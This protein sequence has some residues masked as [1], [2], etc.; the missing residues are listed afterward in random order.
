MSMLHVHF[1]RFSRW[2]SLTFV[3]RH[4]MH[5]YF[6]SKCISLQI[7]QMRFLFF[8]VL[9]QSINTKTLRIYKKYAL[10]SPHEYMNFSTFNL[11]GWR[12][13]LYVLLDIFFM[14]VEIIHVPLHLAF[15]AYVDVCCFHQCLMWRGESWWWFRLQ[16]F[17]NILKHFTTPSILKKMYIFQKRIHSN[18]LFINKPF[19]NQPSAHFYTPVAIKIEESH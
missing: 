9:M 6:K 13:F 17:S 4:L 18:A 1:H 19:F 16:N 5:F 3:A 8:G 14:L 10:Y 2:T 12:A 15:G 11:R 7:F